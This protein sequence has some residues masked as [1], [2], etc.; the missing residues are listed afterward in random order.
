MNSVAITYQIP[1]ARWRMK[2]APSALET[3]KRNVQHGASSKEAVGQLYSRD[4]TIP[5][6]EICVATRLTPLSAT[7]AK[8]KFDP[9]VALRERR[10]F[11]SDGLHCVGL[12]HTH[13]EPI[14]IPSSDDRSLAKEHAQAAKPNLSGLVFAIV[15]TAQFPRGLQ[16][17]VHDGEALL[18]TRQ[19]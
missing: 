11:L 14:P 13:P 17:W 7:F 12:W 3:L 9:H 6:I 4:L 5:E 2:F 16:V 8:V 18:G 15:G 1:G 10:S 19:S